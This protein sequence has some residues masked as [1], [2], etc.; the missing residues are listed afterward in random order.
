VP[1]EKLAFKFPRDI[2]TWTRIV[3]WFGIFFLGGLLKEVLGWYPN[4][5]EPWWLKI[6]DFFFLP[7]DQILSFVIT[8]GFYWGILFL[9][10][11]LG[12]FRH[13]DNPFTLV[14]PVFFMI[15]VLGAFVSHFYF[16]LKSKRV[17]FYALLVALILMQFF[18]A[19]CE[20]DWR[21][22]TALVM[23]THP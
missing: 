21:V 3:L 2:S 19:Y 15:L 5:G 11:V 7:L 18:G 10:Y 13:G 1:A 8:I 4:S 16:F 12:A 17:V 22:S 23:P 9:V 14:V 6:L 20:W